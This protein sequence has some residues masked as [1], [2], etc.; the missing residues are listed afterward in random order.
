MMENLL[1]FLF[2]PPVAQ[3][4]GPECVSSENVTKLVI[5]PFQDFLT[6]ILPTYDVIYLAIFQYFSLLV[7]LQLQH[8]TNTNLQ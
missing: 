6:G 5:N 4:L 7:H 2:D 3:S 1:R 8:V